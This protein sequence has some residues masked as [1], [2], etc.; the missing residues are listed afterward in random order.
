MVKCN[1]QCLS[2]G[3][4]CPVD[5]VLSPAGPWFCSLSVPL[6]VGA[7]TLHT[8]TR[9]HAH[10]YTHAQMRPPP[11]PVFKCDCFFLSLAFY[12]PL[13]LALFSSHTDGAQPP[14]I[15]VLCSPFPSS[16]NGANSST[17]KGRSSPISMRS[18]QRSRPRRTAPRG[19]TKAYLPSPSTC[20]FTRLMVRSHNSAHLVEWHHAITLL[21][22][23]R[24]WEAESYHVF[25]L[26][27]KCFLKKNSSFIFKHTILMLNWC[28]DCLHC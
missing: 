26:W 1:E 10:T 6:Q 4:F 21:N 22:Q 15:S 16:Q 19:P 20:G 23:S 17:A 3:T 25:S 14:L 13:T 28:P 2:L 7:H 8:H 12:P 18:A 24:L 27:T 9:E 11:L 5:L